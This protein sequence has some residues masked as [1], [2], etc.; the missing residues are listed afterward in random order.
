MM[1]GFRVLLFMFFFLFCFFF[2]FFFSSRR[3]HTRST[4][5]WSSD[6]CSSDL[7]WTCTRRAG[8]KCW[9]P[10]SR[11]TSSCA[12]PELDAPGP[13][14]QPPTAS[15]N[16]A[17]A[18]AAAP[19][20]ALRPLVRRTHLHLEPVGPDRAVGVRLEAIGAGRRERELHVAVLAGLVAAHCGA[21]EWLPGLAV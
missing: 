18:A 15:A 19:A 7:S 17:S 6:V 3:R 4:R 1:F 5:D 8:S 12:P 9:R 11:V 14:P 21:L 20:T 13:N 10:K 16:A 2:F